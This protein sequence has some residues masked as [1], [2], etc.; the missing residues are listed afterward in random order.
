MSSDNSSPSTGKDSPKN[1]NKKETYPQNSIADLRQKN[2]LPNGESFSDEE[3]FKIAE[4][5]GIEKPDLTTPLSEEAIARL[6]VNKDVRLALI[7]QEIKERHEN[8]KERFETTKKRLDELR[9]K[10]SSLKESYTDRVNIA[11]EKVE[12]KE[13]EYQKNIESLT[14]ESIKEHFDMN[15]GV[16]NLDSRTAAF[17][18]SQKFKT[19]EKRDK[20][21]NDKY[22]ELENRKQEKKAAK[23]KIRKAFSQMRIERVEKSIQK[24][25]GKNME[26]SAVLQKMLNHQADKYIKHK[27]NQIEKFN[28]K[29]THIERGIDSATARQKQI[30]ASQD[31]VNNNRDDLASSLTDNKGL[32]AGVERTVIRANN[33]SLNARIKMLNAINGVCSMTQ[34]AIK[35]F[36]N[37]FKK[38]M[39]QEQQEGPAL[40]MS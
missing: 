10:S 15:T 19:I 39:K 30:K 38:K 6:R 25:Q 22:V 17:F 1:D 20:K 40:S 26:A 35:H 32:L 7:N 11:N 23:G 21:L 24:L 14:A 36:E 16:M 29:A 12:G 34:K 31:I 13:S 9:E 3:L 18:A 28:S 5:L 27:Q 2:K 37:G 8:Q 33:L 4:S